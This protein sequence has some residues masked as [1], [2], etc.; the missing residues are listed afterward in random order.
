M[1]YRVA[2]DE[3]RSDGPVEPADVGGVPEPGV[4]AVRHQ[5]VVLPLG[6]LKMETSHE[7]S[8]NLEFIYFSEFVSPSATLIGT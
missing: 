4:D 6:A 1:V 5:A 3:L 7:L 2:E 8:W